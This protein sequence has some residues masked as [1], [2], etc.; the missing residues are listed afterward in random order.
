LSNAN[1]AETAFV[2]MRCNSYNL[3]DPI[4][5]AGSL[6]LSN[7]KDGR[8]P[9]S[10]GLE[11]HFAPQILR[12]TICCRGD[13]VVL[14]ACAMYRDGVGFERFRAVEKAKSL[15]RFALNTLRTRQ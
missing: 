6:L 10:V 4:A 9:K 5:T 12:L 7:L 11:L 13:G 3:G 14:L 15:A 2:F 8:I 1:V